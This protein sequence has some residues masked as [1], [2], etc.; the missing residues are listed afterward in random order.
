MLIRVFLRAGMVRT[1][2]TIRAQRTTR[3]QG[4]DEFRKLW[5]LGHELPQ[6]NRPLRRRE[7]FLQVLTGSA[8]RDWKKLDHQSPASPRRVFR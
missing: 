8:R 6:L 7:R 2:L 5:A 4:C 1:S 3:S